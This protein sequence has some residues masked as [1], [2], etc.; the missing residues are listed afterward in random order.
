MKLNA[1][2]KKMINYFNIPVKLFFITFA[3]LNS[4]NATA[5]DVKLRC[6]INTKYTYFTGQSEVNQSTA[7]V[8]ISENSNAKS[9][10]LTS[11]DENANEISVTSIP[12]Q[13]NRVQSE[14]F[15]SSTSSKWDVSQSYNV[16]SKNQKST[17]RIIIDRNTGEII[18]QRIFDN[19]SRVSTTSI[20]GFC[21]K[22]NTEKKKF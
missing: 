17:N 14:G 15:D 4:S 8:E 11:S 13:N 20:S 16:P 5:L 6:N 7:I 3:I 21:E 12:F 1:C 19:N 9:I 18:V 10:F 2:S 22:V